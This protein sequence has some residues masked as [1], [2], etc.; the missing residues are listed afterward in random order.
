MLKLI[1]KIFGTKSDKDIKRMMPLVEETKKEGEK[2]PRLSNDQLRQ[3]TQDI[4]NE[5]N[6]KLKPI[7]DQLAA[8]HKQISDQPNLDINEKEGIFN[9]IDAI[10]KDRNKELE[11]VLMEVLPRAFAIVRETAR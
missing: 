6:Q 5:I 4:Q 7:D 8:L 2:L 9:Q 10:E 3:R 1:A 11:K